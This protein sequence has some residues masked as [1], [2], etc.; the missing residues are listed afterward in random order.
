[1]ARPSLRQLSQRITAR[2]HLEAL[3]LAETQAYIA[4]RLAIAGMPAHQ[5]PF[6]SDIIKKVHQF[7]GGVPRLI[8]ILCERM[9]LGAYSKNQRVID[10]AVFQQAAIEV[11]GVQPESSLARFALPRWH[12]GMVAGLVVLLI[13]SFFLGRNTP[14]SEPVIASE[15]AVAAEVVA[16][17]ENSSAVTIGD[18]ALE[19]EASA[20]NLAVL[21]TAQSPTQTNAQAIFW[22]RD[23]V[24][25]QQALFAYI[26]IDPADNPCITDA[27]FSCE[28]PQLSTWNDL[29]D[30]NHPA[31]LTLVT[32]DK[33]LAYATLIGLS[34]ARALLLV[35]NLPVAV[36]W[37]ELAALWNGDVL[38]VWRRPA[39]FDRPIVLG[40][41]GRIVSWLAQQFATLDQ[42]AAP[43]SRDTYNQVMKK[44]VE[45]FQ[46]SQGL[47]PDGIVGAQTLRRLNDALGVDKTLVTDETD[48]Q[49]LSADGAE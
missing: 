25:A 45:I 16:S 34:D 13:G 42:Q 48:F 46:A 47:E 3:S 22:E 35:D 15:L 18:S 23:L 8:N 27:V 49:A 43:L 7:S 26:D 37:Q 20:V 28:R 12:L 19:T 44:R 24:R 14:R 9:L 32:D 17:A 4:H 1:L 39:G 40:D 2:F 6:P 10:Q 21:P 33:K 11:S 41:K 31:V 38:Y 5:N 30:I 36:D 29:R